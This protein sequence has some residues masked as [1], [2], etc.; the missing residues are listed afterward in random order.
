MSHHMI[1]EIK[2]FPIEW[3]IKK[4]SNTTW[5]LKADSKSPQPLGIHIHKF[6][7]SIDYSHKDGFQATLGEF[8][9][10]FCFISPLRTTLKQA[11]KDCLNF[12]D[13]FKTKKILKL[14]L[15]LNSL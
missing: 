14:F 7:S 2:F 12:M 3:K 1:S 8:A 11:I 13:H 6:D 9:G 5:D 4:G 15:N 10:R